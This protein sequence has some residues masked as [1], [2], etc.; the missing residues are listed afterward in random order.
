MATVK[1]TTARNVSFETLYGGQF[2]LSTRLIKLN[3]PAILF[4]RRSTTFSSETYQYKIWHFPLNI[5]LCKPNN[6]NELSIIS[7]TPQ[8]SG[9]YRLKIS[10]DSY[11]SRA[12]KE[13]SLCLWHNKP[14]RVVHVSFFF[15]SCRETFR[16]WWIREVL[17]TKLPCYQTLTGW[18]WIRI[19]PILNTEFCNLLA[20]TVYLDDW[21]Q[22]RM[23]SRIP[24]NGVTSS[25][26][27][28]DIQ[29]AKIWLVLKCI[30][31]FVNKANGGK[32]PTGV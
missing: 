32:H 29:T 2:T 27:V 17:W 6:L 3:Y 10:N 19:F 20:I 25:S 14:T 13:S 30:E 7:S 5:L 28:C 9:D 22:C 1:R 8:A 18:N 16:I 15:F 31:N 26:F 4:H 24:P 23:L 11:I 12:W 21:W